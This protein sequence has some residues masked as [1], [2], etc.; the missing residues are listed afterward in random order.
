MANEE[1]NSVLA[2]K[3][4][5]MLHFL[6]LCSWV[7]MAKKNLCVP[8]CL[9][10]LQLSL[11]IW[12]AMNLKWNNIIQPFILRCSEQKKNDEEE[13]QKKNLKQN[14]KKNNNKNS[15]SDFNVVVSKCKIEKLTHSLNSRR[16]C[17]ILI[18]CFV[19]FIIQYE[20]ARCLPNSCHFG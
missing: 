12:M 20:G 16:A 2:C 15:I 18:E 13:E 6:S 17:F 7:S 1:S 4:K 19:L 11:V 5:Q 3:L 14:S 9:I 10:H 8:L